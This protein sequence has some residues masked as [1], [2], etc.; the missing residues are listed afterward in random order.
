MKP[1]FTLFAFAAGLAASAQGPLRL[2]LQQAQDLAAQ[3][4]YSVQASALEAEKA[5]HKVKEI[6]AIGLPQISGEAQL[7]NFIDVP[8]QLVPNF[9]TP[10]IGPEFVAAQFSLPWNTSAGVT[11]SQ[12]IFDGSYI[13]GL[14]ATRALA[15]QSREE[16]EKTRADARNQ[17]A[18][19]YFGVL[20]AEEGARLAGEGIPL[21]EQSLREAQ[22]MLDAGFME[23]TDVDRLTIQLDQTR[24]QQRSF[25]QQANVARMLLALTLG[26]P[27]GT[28]ITLA[29]DLRAIVNDPNE[30]ALSEQPFAAGQHIESQSTETLVRLQTLNMRNERAKGL[31]SLAGF[32]NHQQVWNGPDFDPGGDYPFYPTTL[33]GLKLSVPI[34][35][36]GNLYHKVKQA[37]VALQQVEINRT[38][39]EQRL[40]AEVER[41]RSQSRTA[42]DNYRSE[43][44][45]LVLSQS[46]LDRTSIKFANGAASSF[47]LT[48]ERA[49]NLMA[50]QQY[51]QR[52]V[53]LLSA[54]ADLRKALDLY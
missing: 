12:L 30:T 39:T 33:W 19:A 34:F 8:T 23:S 22:A 2:T 24:A 16:L 44:R 37:Q 3:Q 53:E 18:K 13:V 48:Q 32:F 38:A 49:N 51:V 9:F 6:T 46:I 52:L 15:Q 28:P 10:G 4:A 26:V 21:I 27:Q 14:Q 29:D 43:E 25:Q 20:A 42:F 36:S 54:R 17:A 47:E 1:L 5:R 45:S 7:Q 41:T 40:L 31:P 35:S 50:Q 11:L